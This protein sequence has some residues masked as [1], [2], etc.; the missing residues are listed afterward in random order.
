[1][2]SAGGAVV[3]L[4][5]VTVGDR[6]LIASAAADGTVTLADPAT[7][8]GRHILRAEPGQVR[9]LVPLVLPGA[10]CLGIVSADGSL[11][12]WAPEQGWG[13]TFT[14]HGGRATTATGA[15]AGRLAVGGVDGTIEVRALGDDHPRWTATAGGGPV[16]A[17]CLLPGLI[18][19]AGADGRIRLRETGSG[20]LRRTLEAPGGSPVALCPMPVAGRT[21][22]GAAGED[23]LVRLWDPDTGER[24][25]E[26][27]G[28][29]GPLTAVCPVPAAGRRT[30]AIASA[31]ADR[32]ARLW[33]PLSGRCLMT[34]P[35]RHEATA[36]AAAGGHLIVGLTAGTVAYELEH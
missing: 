13:Q 18:A 36:C 26:L 19:A 15:D 31:G 2:P 34:V 27:A 23:G 24:R 20:A 10:T 33:D 32:T 35:L 14:V 16:A 28:H 6:L 4:C 5:R 9:A 25:H 22:L 12:A 11:T 30:V 8:Q 29:S 7:G 17:L 3:V 21:L 1:V